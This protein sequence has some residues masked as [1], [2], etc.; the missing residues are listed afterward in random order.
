MGAGQRQANQTV[1]HR[2]D[3]HLHAPNELPES[4]GGRVGKSAPDP[5]REQHA[6]GC[7]RRGMPVSPLDVSTSENC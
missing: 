5:L 7:S 4:Q 6:M 3:G 2:S 1:A